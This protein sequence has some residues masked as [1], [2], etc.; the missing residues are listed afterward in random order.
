[1]AKKKDN[2]NTMY[3]VIFGIIIL[4]LWKLGPSFMGAAV[5][6]QG[7]NE[8]QF[9]KSGFTCATDHGSYDTVT[10]KCIADLVGG[11][12]LTGGT[13]VDTKCH[14]EPVPTTAVNEITKYIQLQS[15]FIKSA[16][17]RLYGTPGLKNAKVEMIYNVLNAE[18]QLT[19]NVET[20]WTQPVDTDGNPVQFTSIIDIPMTT[21]LSGKEA[22][23]SIGFKFSSQLVEDA[24][25]TQGSL[26]VSSFDVDWGLTNAERAACNTTNGTFNKQTYAC[27]C[28]AKS[29][30]N[31]NFTSYALATGCKWDEIKPVVTTGTTTT[32][33]TTGTTTT[34]EECG[35]SWSCTQYTACPTIDPKLYF[36]QVY[37]TRTCT[38]ANK[39]GTVKNKP[40]E[41]ILCKAPISKNVLL[42]TGL[43][44]VALM[45]Y[46]FA[47]ERGKKGL[48]SWI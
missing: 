27:D 37:Q 20:I 43:I 45:I 39:C 17:M 26:I 8:M 25:V 22:G 19:P 3:L 41:K 23:D 46:Y 47:Y 16:N 30:G 40:T 13:I 15:R 1:M 33:T 44:I 12:C 6:F 31:S 18:G 38:D 10:G 21:K 2:K 35:E 24:T 5:T 4:I 42:I 32:T 9:A 34:T 14:Y 29:G 11:A 7:G 48:V 28:P 36:G